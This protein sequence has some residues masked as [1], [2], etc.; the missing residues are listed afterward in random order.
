MGLTTMGLT[1]KRTDD[2]MN[3]SRGMKNELF[4]QMDGVDSNK[5]IFIMAATNTPY[6]LDVAILRRFDRLFLVPLPD[7]QERHQL[8]TKNAD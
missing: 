7:D 8:F 1:R 6:D 5:G 2:D 3:R 4:A